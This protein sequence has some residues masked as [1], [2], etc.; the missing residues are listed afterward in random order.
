M[1]LFQCSYLITHPGQAV[2]SGR[3]N[4]LLV[5]N[6][7]VEEAAAILS[8]QGHVDQDHDIKDVNLTI[9]LSTPRWCSGGYVC[10]WCLAFVRCG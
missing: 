5:D 4:P 3:G 9:W 2:R 6:P 8:I 10:P 1:C 7:L